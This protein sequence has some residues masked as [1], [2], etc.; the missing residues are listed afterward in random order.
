M[1]VNYEIGRVGKSF[2]VQIR[3]GPPVSPPTPPAWTRCHRAHAHAHAHWCSTPHRIESTS[4]PPPTCSTH[5][6]SLSR[7]WR[8]P[9]PPHFAPD[10]AIV[11]HLPLYALNHPVTASKCACTPPL[12]RWSAPSIYEP[13]SS[14]MHPP[15]VEQWFVLEPTSAKKFPQSSQ[16][17][18]HF[19][20]NNAPL[21]TLR[22]WPGPVPFRPPQVPRQPHNTLWPNGRVFWLSVQALAIVPTAADPI[23]LSLWPPRHLKS[24][25]HSTLML[26]VPSSLSFTLSMA[27]MTGPPPALAW[28]HHWLGSP[29][30]DGLPTRES[31][32]PLSWARLE[33]MASFSLVTRCILLF[34]H[35]IYFKWVPNLP[36]FLEIQINSRKI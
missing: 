32:G 28:M 9:P 35:L 17:A 7:T 18:P 23:P 14:H 10:S 22:F 27:R 31:G 11:S 6:A 13:T 24:V 1:F 5:S 21:A 3:P 15:S 4:M 2:K 20:H 30:R 29:V 26:L 34:F 12:L 36:K 33:P 16:A 25:Q 19:Y 8:Q